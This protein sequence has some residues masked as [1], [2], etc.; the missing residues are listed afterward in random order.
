MNKK[1]WNNSVVYQIYPKSFNDTNRDG[2]GDLNGIIEK[3]DYLKEL[4]ID[5]IWLSPVYE[6]PMD[7]NGYDISDYE[8]ISKEFGTMEEMDRLI[9]E[10]DDRGIKI[11]M[12][13]VINHS[14][15]EHPWFIE[16]KSSRENPKRDWYIW[17]D[18]NESGSSPNN[19][20]SIFGGSCWEFDE[21][22]GQYYFHSFSKKQPDLNWENPH[23]REEIYRMV[24]WWLDKGIGGFRVD[25]ITFIKKPEKFIEE[26]SDGVD[27]LR[28]VKPNQPGV[29]KFLAELKK[30]TFAHYNIFTVAEAPGVE[31]DQ[32]AEYSGDEGYF[33][34][35]IRF[36]HVDLDM[37]E[38]GKWYT[39]NKW[40][41]VD[42][43]KA[44]SKNQE[45]IKGNYT[46]ALYLENHDQPRS[47]NRSIPKED[48]NERSAKL[49]ATSYFFLKGMPYIYQGQEIGMTNIEYS[50]I[51]SY[52]DIS[53]IDQY[54]AAL[55]AGYSKE[56]AMSFVYRRSRDNA[57]TPMQWS[58]KENAGFSEVSPWLQVNPN[59]KEI[60][61]KKALE[62]KNSLFYYYQN[63][64]KIRK[65]P[66]Y[67]DVLMSGDYEELFKDH[68]E[69][70]VYLRQLNDQ[71]LLV[72]TNFSNKDV[73]LDLNE[74]AKQIVIGNYEDTPMLDGEVMVRPYECMVYEL[75]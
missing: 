53:T 68:L 2:I 6:S 34:M 24:R 29:G 71:K 37:G 66:T 30:Q 23:L 35:L 62:N 73:H 12:D 60:N 72:I 10:A 27:G 4:G 70:F 19:L 5:V 17:R 38:D 22:T 47:L 49:L 69:V 16:S 57:R 11:I 18:G 31:L 25:A 36:D 32:L 50:T 1:W 40:T 20:R 26:V 74:K 21:G 64:I 65:N 61:V 41:L 14:S 8:N 59:Y 56:K 44:I 58:D 3:L 13:L 51:E 42:F 67:V 52:D 33:D 46:T 28:V 43:K 15:D 55:E 7:D 45:A 63:L 9:Q 39:N 48:I 54:N 75:D